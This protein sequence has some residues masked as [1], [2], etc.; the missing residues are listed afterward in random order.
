MNPA[1]CVTVGRFDL[2]E[3]GEMTS[4][5]KIFMATSSSVRRLQAVTVVQ[6][7]DADIWVTG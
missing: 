1:L 3:S 7:E 5:V 6:L 4:D 2:S